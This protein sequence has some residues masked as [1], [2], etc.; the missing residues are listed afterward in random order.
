MLK[1]YNTETRQK[2]IV[3]G[4]KIRLYTCGPTVYNFAHIGN[5]RTFVFED[6]LKRTLKFFGMDVHHVM[7][8]TDVEDKTIKGAMEKGMKLSEYTRIYK[9]AF[10]DDLKTLSID[11][12]DEYPAATDHIGDMIDMIQTLMGKGVA[13]VGKDNSIYFSIHKFPSYGR[14]SHFKLSDLKQGASERQ[15]MDEYD[16]ESATDFVLW[17]SYDQER[18]GDVFWESP[19]GRG[20]PGWHIECSAMAMKTL[21]E[22]IDI[23]AG[24]VDNIFPHHE[25]EIA[26]SEACTGHPFVK[27]WVHA[28]HLIVDG[29]KMSK[30]LGNF[31]T[32]RDLLG[33]GYTGDEVRYL[34][35]SAHYRTQLNFT[36]DGL[37]AA[38]SALSRVEAFANRLRTL[39]PSS[40]T[41]DLT[42]HKDAFAAALADDLNISSAL[43]SLFDLIRDANSAADAQTLGDPAPILDFLASVNQVIGILPLTPK[44]LDIP[45]DIQEAFDA[46]N[47]ARAAKDWALADAKRDYILE[48]GYQI[49]DTPQGPHLTRK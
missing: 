1:L 32:L 12:A 4:E 14:L 27:H 36:L 21:G 47:Q 9:D 34:L 28:E 5:L 7:N 10:F 11:L 39:N 3:E 37:T 35:L 42:P 25:N 26:Q 15:S 16:K 22:T 33:N 46:R 30:S 24:G 20:R 13:Y 45:P 38:R 6:L 40:G 49:E 48:R 43:A 8:L 18:D 29:K 19:F 31:F 2:D 41:F 44:T 17:K 23:H